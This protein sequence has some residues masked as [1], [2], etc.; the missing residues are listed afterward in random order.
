MLNRQSLQA[1]PSQQLYQLKEHSGTRTSTVTGRRQ[2]PAAA[3]NNLMAGQEL[4][5]AIGAP[6]DMSGLNQIRSSFMQ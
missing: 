2:R 6:N 1:V 5:L 3:V 4:V